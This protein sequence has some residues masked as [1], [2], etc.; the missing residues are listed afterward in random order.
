MSA[1]YKIQPNVNQVK[2]S[3]S[4]LG[5][6]VKTQLQPSHPFLKAFEEVL[7]IDAARICQPWLHNDTLFKMTPIYKVHTE[8]RTT[9]Y[10]FINR[11][12]TIVFSYLS[13]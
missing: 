7:K 3:E 4:T 12:N 6:E 13:Q 9:L 1:L 11:V 2:I 10:G 8:H 5:V